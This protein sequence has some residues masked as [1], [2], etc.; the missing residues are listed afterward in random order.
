MTA[1]VEAEPAELLG[2]LR[3]L[4]IQLGAHRESTEHVALV[5]GRKVFRRRNGEFLLRRPLHLH[6]RIGAD[7][8]GTDGRC[9]GRRDLH[10]IAA[11]RVAD[12]GGL[13]ACDLG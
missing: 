9:G 10:E 6:A 12:L 13:I 11:R 5:E 1:G 7:A 8:N 2:P 3:V 4:F